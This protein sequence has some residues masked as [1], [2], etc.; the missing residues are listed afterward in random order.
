MMIQH[1]EIRN[2]FGQIYRQNVKRKMP[3]LTRG[4]LQIMYMYKQ[5]SIQ[6][7]HHTRSRSYYPEC[8]DQLDMVS[9]KKSYSNGLKSFK[10]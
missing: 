8:Q 3:R 4:R 6:T 7:L 10:A 9:G 1:H 5:S 2:N